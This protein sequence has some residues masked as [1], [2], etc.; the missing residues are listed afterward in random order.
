MVYSF[1][2]NV[3]PEWI[4]YNGHMRDSYY[5]LVFSLAVDAFQDE[6]GFDEAYR[7]RT[8]C[9]IYLLEDHKFFLRE[10]KEG[11][12]V[13]VETR[14]VGCDSKRFHLHM[15][16]FN[17][18][19]LASVGEFMELHVCQHPQPHAMPMPEEILQKLEAARLSESEAEKLPR[20]SRGLSL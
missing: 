15:Q 12:R 19:A 13:R 8:G 10:V 6:I 9:T 1:E 5:G 18:T 7:R 2:T 14:I 20:R 3:L 11:A 16:M 17:G 4:D